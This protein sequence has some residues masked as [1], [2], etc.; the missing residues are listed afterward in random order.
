MKLPLTFRFAFA[1]F[2][3]A[4]IATACGDALSP[5]ER[6]LPSAGPSAVI[7]PADTTGGGSGSGGDP[8]TNTSTCGTAYRM[9]LD[10]GGLKGLLKSGTYALFAAYVYDASGC[11]LTPIF[12]WSMS[13]TTVASLTNPSTIGAGAQ[14]LGKLAGQSILTVTA[15]GLSLSYNVT[16]SPGDPHHVVLTPTSLSLQPGG[17]A[18]VTAAMYDSYNNKLSSD[19]DWSINNTRLSISGTGTI[20][21]VRVTA[22]TALPVSPNPATLTA[23]RKG[24]GSPY[25]SI[26]VTVVVP[27]CYCPPGVLCYCAPAGNP[28]L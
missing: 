10:D 23:K 1:T 22:S 13:N 28:S 3:L 12:N 21:T 16:V 15:A 9:V 19:F 4:G 11:R 5:T 24:F 18:N 20:G 14:V 8:S 26:P 25:A 2:T 6:A 27:E 7:A 17:Y